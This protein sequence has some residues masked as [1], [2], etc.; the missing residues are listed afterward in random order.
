M[1]LH[2]P[3]GEGTELRFRKRRQLSQE[4]G[5]QAVGR[6]LSKEATK[7]DSLQRQRSRHFLAGS[8]FKVIIVWIPELMV[9]SLF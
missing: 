8:P 3:S 1:C 7:F 6:G 2:L 4:R 5:Y 9:S